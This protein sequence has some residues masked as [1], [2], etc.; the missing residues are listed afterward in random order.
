MSADRSRLRLWRDAATDELRLAGRLDVSTVADVRIALHEA[1]DRGSG[2]LVVNLAEVEVGDA[3]GLGVLVGAHRRAGRRGRRLVLRG[4]PPRLQRLL[5][6]T[7]LH[8]ILTIDYS[9]RV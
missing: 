5:A 1:L 2:D 8:R 6:A 4:V 7:K 9:V 3:T